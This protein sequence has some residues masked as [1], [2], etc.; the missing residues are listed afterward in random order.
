MIK[1]FLRFICNELKPTEC[2]WWLWKWIFWKSFSNRHFLITVKMY[3]HQDSP[4]SFGKKDLDL[5][6]RGPGTKPP[7]RAAFF[8]VNQCLINLLK[9]GD[10]NRSS[11]HAVS[12]V[13]A[14]AG[15]LVGTLCLNKDSQ[16][17][18]QEQDS[19]RWDVFVRP[20]P[21]SRSSS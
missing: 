7:Y 14:W 11:N 18:L 16:W 6:V 4:S 17:A 21:C 9:S 15:Q 2:S 1:S 3:F 5:Q 13:P 20:F 10:Y 12:V 19:W 8:L